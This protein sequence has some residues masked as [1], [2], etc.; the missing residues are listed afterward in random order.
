MTLDLHYKQ[1]LTG[2]DCGYTP[3]RR[4]VSRV[5]ERSSRLADGYFTLERIGE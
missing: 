1:G 4:R 2:R 5:S 3:K